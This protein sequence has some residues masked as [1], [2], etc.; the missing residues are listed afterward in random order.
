MQGDLGIA[1]C[2]QCLNINFYARLPPPLSLPPY[3]DRV[4]NRVFF[5]VLLVIRRG[6]KVVEV[7]LEEDAHLE[8]PRQGRLVIG[9]IVGLGSVPCRGPV[10]KPV[11][12]SRFLAFGCESLLQVQWRC[13]RYCSVLLAAAPK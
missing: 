4:C 12:G 10:V 11:A 2:E 3:R 9:C 8:Q 6:K 7:T 13:C 1:I 5:H